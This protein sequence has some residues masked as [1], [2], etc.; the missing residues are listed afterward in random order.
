MKITFSDN[1]I[2]KFYRK[3]KKNLGLGLPTLPVIYFFY[4]ASWK[5]ISYTRVIQ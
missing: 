5:K 3:K 1:L 2:L 4:L